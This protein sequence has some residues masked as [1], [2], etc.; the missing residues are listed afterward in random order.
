MARDPDA[1]K[2]SKWAASG[3]VEDPEDGGIDRD[4]GWDASHSQPGGSLPK[5]E[6]INE[7]LREVT[8]LGV[9]QNVHGAGLEWDSSISYEH[10]AWVTGSDARL[11]GSV[12]DS[13]GV[14][15]VGDDDK[16]H[17]RPLIDSDTGVIVPPPN[18]SATERGIV[19]LATNAE[20]AAGTDAERAITPAGLAS[21]RR[22]R[23]TFTRYTTPGAFT[24][25]VP[26]TASLA[27]CGKTL[28]SAQRPRRL[29]DK[30]QISAFTE[31]IAT[32]HVAYYEYRR[33]VR[34]PNHRVCSP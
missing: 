7:I 1:L 34:R 22:S 27:G 9:E 15:P 3:D 13:T 23:V 20:A 26:P 33:F 31:R 14:D 5:R 25:T 16:S 6:H 12:Q 30:C 32:R 17:W 21:D 24:Y 19:E 10:P 11:Y 4:I 28:R 18:A 8:A 29:D 2:I